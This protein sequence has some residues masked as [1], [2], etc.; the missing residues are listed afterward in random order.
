MG[1]LGIKALE[2]FRAPA[3]E[4]FKKSRHFDPPAKIDELGKMASEIVFSWQPDRRGLVLNRRDAGTDPHG[5]ANI[6]C[7]QPFACLPNHVVG[8]GVIKELWRR[9]PNSNVVAI[10]FDP[11]ASEVNH[12]TGSL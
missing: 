1:N 7:T 4:A 5:A 11:G 12:R 9:H 2:W 8:K 3:T 6:V 10:D